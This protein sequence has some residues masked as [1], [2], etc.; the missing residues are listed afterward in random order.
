MTYLLNNCNT[1]NYNNNA[2][3][4]ALNGNL[5][6]VGSNGQ[7]SYYG[8]FDQSGNINELLDTITNNYPI[9]R[10]GSFS[11]GID[12]LKKTFVDTNFFDSK[13]SDLGFRIA[14]TSTSIDSTNY[15]LVGNISNAS[16]S[17]NN[18]IGA[19]N[20]SYQ[21]KKYLITNNEYA[22]FLNAVASASNDLSLW[23]SQM[24]DSSQR[25]GISRTGSSGNYVYIVLGNM[26]NKPVNFINWFCAARYINWLSN[27]KPT[28]SP[29]NSTTEDG[30]YTLS[31]GLNQGTSKPSK[32][33]NNSYWIPNQNEWYKAAYYDPTKS[34]GAGYWLYATQTDSSPTA[35]TADSNG[36]AN[37][38]TNLGCVTPTPTPT[39]SVTPSQT[40]TPSVSITKTPT[41]SI[42]AT[43]TNTP[44]KT[45]TPSHTVTPSVTKTKTPTPTNS[46]TPTRTP[47]IS[48]TH[49]VTP[50]V[51]PTHTKT[52]TKSVTPTLTVT[53]SK[54]FCNPITVGSLIYQNNVFFNDNIQV[55]YKGLLFNSKLIPNYTILYQSGFPVTSISPSTPPRNLIAENI[56]I[57]GQHYIHISWDPP[58]KLNI[59]STLPGP[60]TYRIDTNLEGMG[61][62]GII[63]YGSNIDYLTA[64]QLPNAGDT[65]TLTVSACD[66]DLSNCGDTASISIEAPIMNIGSPISSPNLSVSTSQNDFIINWTIPSL[67]GAILIGYT[68]SCPQL[69]F[70]DDL[71]SASYTNT[72]SNLN[73]QLNTNYIFYVSACRTNNNHDYICDGAVSSIVVSRPT[74]T[75]TPTPTKTR[76]P[77]I[78]RTNTPTI[79]NTAGVTPTPT[80]TPTISNTSSVTPTVTPSVTNTATPTNT[81]T[82]TV[83]PTITLTATST[84]TPSSSPTPTAT[85]TPTP[86]PTVTIS[87]AVQYNNLV[88]VAFGQNKSSLSSNGG[89]SWTTNNLTSSAYWTSVAYGLSR[90]VACAYNSDFVNAS[91]NG[92]S[93]T[94]YSISNLGNAPKL[95][96]K[97]FFGNNQF[98]MLENSSSVGAI[99]SDG[100]SWSEINLPASTN[101]ANGAYGNN[102]YVIVPKMTTSVYA[103]STNGTTWTQRTLPTT[104][105]WSD[106]KFINNKFIIVATSSDTILSSSDGLNWT[107]ATLS[108]Q[109]QWS[110]VAYGN[111][112]YV[113]ASTDNQLCVS[114]D[115]TSWTDISSVIPFNST[116]SITFNSGN[117][118]IINDSF[119]ITSTNGTTWTQRTIGSYNW[120]A[121]V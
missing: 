2:S 92:S 21:I 108:T 87:P 58:E 64:L 42:S 41:T 60:Y 82:S 120:Y 105:F 88:A 20:Y 101:W 39:I 32:N 31:N 106:L 6:T 24:G 69:G 80:K 107:S 76:T 13:R 68:I 95:W 112:T 83:S 11:G 9:Y 15:V 62:E 30:V 114:S 40:V 118:V 37:G 54:S 47:T 100:Y 55:L 113:V 48:L 63:G 93:W 102:L 27:N 19:V 3:W 104:K 49:S 10:G 38:P 75:P 23:V 65:I 26:G 117:F 71:T 91:S 89:T 56:T 25:G 14:K 22:E 86:T 103:T 4:N 110:S 28:G 18:N 35:I 66:K 73:M 72:Y 45:L 53:P 94:S 29:S 7:S 67:N 1:A 109:A 5:T 115:G 70:S 46:V 98:I 78:T 90:Y 85:K 99:S 52:P 17:S 50:T 116:P 81:V 12:T 84:V 36:D 16:D 34:G 111:G 119:V 51:T 8:T 97:V 77:T 79:S 121:I 33:N 61:D 57:N 44:T 96:T 74:G 43:P 59:L